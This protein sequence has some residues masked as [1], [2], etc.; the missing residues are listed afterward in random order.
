MKEIGSSDLWDI[1]IEHYCSKEER[2]ILYKLPD[3]EYSKIDWCFTQLIVDIK[4][5]LEKFK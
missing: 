1:I 2:S 5:L 3:I 4:E